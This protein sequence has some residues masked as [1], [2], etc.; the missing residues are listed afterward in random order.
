M[1]KLILILFIINLPGSLALAQYKI[2]WWVIGAGGGHS[3]SANYQLD[4][5]IGQ[6]IVGQSTSPNY[7]AD[8]GFW[9]G[10]VPQGPVCD[11]TVGDAN[12]S[13]SFNGLDVTYGVTYFKGGPPPPYSCE[14]TAG[15]TW[16]V[17]GDVNQSCSY[18]GLDI[19]YAVSY[20][21]G[22]PAPL[23]CGDCPPARGLL[24]AKPISI[25]KAQSSAP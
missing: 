2:D 21:K 16:Y 10:T 8:G 18:N 4:G 23:P 12:N 3:Q 13:G 24:G 1:K 5:T 6:P 9:I 22:G 11:Y 14:C 19:T 15:H 17:A 7:R 20:L 25:R